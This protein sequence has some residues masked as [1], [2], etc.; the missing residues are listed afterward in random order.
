VILYLLGT[1]A[2]WLGGVIGGAGIRAGFALGSVGVWLRRCGDRRHDRRYA[3]PYA[4]RK[5]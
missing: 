1:L 4:T 3:R 5:A 2:I